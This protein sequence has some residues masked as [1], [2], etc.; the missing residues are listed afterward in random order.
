MTGKSRR[1]QWTLYWGTGLGFPSKFVPKIFCGIDSERFLGKSAPFTEFFVS[2]VSPFRGLK[3]YRTEFSNK[4]ILKVLACFFGPWMVRNEFPTG[5][6]FADWFIW[7]LNIFV[8]RGSVRNK[9]AKFPEL[10]SLTKWF[11]DFYLLQNYS[12]WNSKDLS[13]FLFY[14]MVRNGI[15]SFFG[16]DRM[17]QISVCSVFRGIISFSKN[18]NPWR[19]WSL[20]RTP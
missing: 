5:F 9:I 6:P 8:F 12:E 1:P 19:A 16:S 18:G 13:V 15:P 4:M 2:R 3:Q 14:E 7:I 10:L 11:G 17:N 20:P